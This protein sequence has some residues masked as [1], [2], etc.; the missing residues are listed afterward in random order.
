M[1]KLFGTEKK[2][3]VEYAPG[4]FYD[5]E[6]TVLGGSWDDL[7]ENKGTMTD[8]RTGEQ[9]RVDV[10]N[11]MAFDL[12]AAQK[13]AIQNNKDQKETQKR[14]QSKGITSQQSILGG[15]GY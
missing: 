8:K 2:S 12:T 5:P 10:N 14:L 11:E 4:R 1:A 15:G 9:F 3:R 6:F 7:Y 13:T